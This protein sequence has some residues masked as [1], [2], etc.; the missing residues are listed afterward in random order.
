MRVLHIYKG[1][2]PDMIG[3]ISEFIKQ[4]SEGT[5][6]HGVK[7]SLLCLSREKSLPATEVMG[8]LTVYRC[9]ISFEISS[10]P[11][12]LKA[13]RL[14]RQLAREHDILHYQH[15]YPFADMLD[16]FPHNKPKLVSYQ[17]DIVRQ[18][19]LD[20]AYAPLQRHFLNN[21][22]RIV[23][24]SQNYL[25]TSAT[26]KGYE[27]KVDIITIGLNEE[28][29]TVNTPGLAPKLPDGISEPFLLFLGAIRYYKDISTLINASRI[30]R[31]PLV[32]AG[33]G[34][35]LPR[36][37]AQA[38]EHNLNNIRFLGEVTNETKQA[39]LQNCRAVILPS[40]LRSEALGVSLIEGLMHGKPL[41]CCEIGTGT[42]FINQHE[43]TGLVVPPQDPEALSAAMCRLYQ[44]E[45]LRAHM[46]AAAR[47]R[48]EAHFTGKKMAEEYVSLYKELLA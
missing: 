4:L 10:T 24:T 36:Y 47:Q 2:Y 16:L 48:F 35:D 44:D 1:Y 11:F 22:G 21:V 15:P 29:S 40:H 26:L 38:Q 12:S 23:T 41:I 42:T 20:K 45:A 17:S 43:L 46:G 30:N 19:L 32:I 34:P 6:K 27:E 37:Q 28:A 18:K 3:G 31:L 14:F 13:L 33:D 5:S 8:Q 9:P 7:N 39:L 25:A